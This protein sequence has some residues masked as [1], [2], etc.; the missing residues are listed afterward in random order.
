LS[1]VEA[2]ED[3]FDFDILDKVVSETRVFDIRDIGKETADQI[4]AVDI[5]DNIGENAI[6]LD[7]RSP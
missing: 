6:F 1:K 5:V 4:T 3:N 2:E 7:I